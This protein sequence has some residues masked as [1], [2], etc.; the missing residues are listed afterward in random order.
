VAISSF[1][2]GF[3]SQRNKRSQSSNSCTKIT[4]TESPSFLPFCPYFAC[5]QVWFHF[6]PPM[7]SSLQLSALLSI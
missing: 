3:N 7:S 1:K 5:R 4:K 6:C 2:Y